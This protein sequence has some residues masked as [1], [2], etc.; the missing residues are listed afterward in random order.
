MT[1]WSST[2][3]EAV[4]V[5]PGV[6]RGRLRVP[7]S[8]SVS[9]RQLALALLARSPV[10]VRNLLRAED[11]DLFLAALRAM[12]WTVEER[13]EGADIDAGDGGR[14]VRLAPGPPPA[15][16]T[17]ECGNA[18][19]LMRFLVALAATVPGSWSLDGTPRLRER[20]VGPLVAA[21]QA[22]GVAVTWHGRE[23]YPPLTVAG[24]TFRGG[25][26]T[27]DA[28]ESSQYLSAL[29]LAALGGREPTRVRV[30][31]LTSAP[32][33]DVTLQLIARWGGRVEA[34]A[35]AFAVTPGLRAPLV[36]VD[37]EGDYSAAAYP[38]AAAALTDGEVTLRGLRRE[39]AQG[40]RAFLDVLRRMGAEVSWQ[41]DELRVAG[42]GALT[43]VDIDMASMPDQVPTLAALAPFARGT[44]TIRNVL[45]LRI[46]ESD[47]LAAMACELRRADAEVEEL[48]DGLVIPGIWADVATSDLPREP[49][50]VDP[51]GDHRIAMSMALVGLRRPGL[52]IAHPE[53]VGKSYPRFWDDLSALCGKEAG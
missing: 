3:A 45:H 18:G 1:A 30:M 41:G 20:P 11:V 36:E 15:A 29:L 33:V 52:R 7:P 37:V 53:V 6:V 44:T 32:Y 40:D 5:R 47:R 25:E 8:K 51:H 28:G 17:L 21:L 48:A 34:S 4:E 13:G 35:G 24:D 38:A 10:E 19:T 43:A 27:I 26:T 46:K 14:T 50:I 31:A 2:L 42:V 49:V 22:L 12:G 39:S 9:H 23:G 16:A